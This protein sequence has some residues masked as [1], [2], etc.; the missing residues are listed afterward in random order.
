MNTI[1]DILA[2]YGCPL[3]DP[4]ISTRFDAWTDR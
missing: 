3:Y 2:D 4:Q 1:M